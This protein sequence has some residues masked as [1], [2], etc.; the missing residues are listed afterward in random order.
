MSTASFAELALSP[1][2]QQT[3][4][5]LGYAAPTPITFS[6]GVIRIRDYLTVTEAVH[7]ADELLYHVKQH[8]KHNIACYEGKTIRLIR[9][10]PDD[11]E[12]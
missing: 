10:L 3:L 5:E 8:G 12:A 9:P 4:S 11:A 7:L 2:L 6:A 1:R